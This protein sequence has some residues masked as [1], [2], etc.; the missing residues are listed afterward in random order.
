[1][2]IIFSWLYLE[3]CLILWIKCHL[4]EKP[5]CLPFPTSFIAIGYFCAKIWRCENGLGHKSNLTK[6]N[7]FGLTSQYFSCTK[8]MGWK[9]RMMIRIQHNCH[10]K[11]IIFRLIHLSPQLS[12]GSKIKTESFK[13]RRMGGSFLTL[14][15][16]N[17]EHWKCW[18]LSIWFVTHPYSEGRLFAQNEAIIMNVILSERSIHGLSNHQFDSQNLPHFQK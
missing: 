7:I 9:L 8:A 17:I 16:R 10:W 12:N 11:C 13:Y 18:I 4:I 5:K 1:M 15:E 3:T 6:F 2:E 14:D